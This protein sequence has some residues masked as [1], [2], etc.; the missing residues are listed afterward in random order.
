MDT[1]DEYIG[2]SH[3]KIYLYIYN[4]AFEPINTSIM[5]IAQ[6]GNSLLLIYDRIGCSMHAGK[7]SIGTIFQ[8]TKKWRAL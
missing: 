4:H 5:C 2:L 6:P 3:N 8:A 7:S 1:R